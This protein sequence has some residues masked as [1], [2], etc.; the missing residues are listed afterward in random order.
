MMGGMTGEVYVDSGLEEALNIDRNSF[1]E[2][3]GHFVHLRE[4]LFRHLGIPNYSGITTDIRERS[5]LR[6]VTLQR[7]KTYDFVDRL[8]R[9]LGRAIGKDWQLQIDTS[10]DSPL[11]VNLDDEV[12]TA[13]PDHET[14]PSTG[15]RATNS[16]AFAWQRA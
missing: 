1:N 8:R 12:V 10:L 14:V 6:Q 5:R 4:S 11:V 16:F 2:T 15:R 13:N 7:D 9:R 3:H